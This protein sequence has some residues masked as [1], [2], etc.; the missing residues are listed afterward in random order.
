MDGRAV[1]GG[2]RL[3]A[4]S[5]SYYEYL[6]KNAI[7]TQSEPNEVDFEMHDSFRRVLRE[8]YSIRRFVGK[9][10]TPKATKKSL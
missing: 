5:D 8:T 7:M 1:G 4:G 2:P 3:G 6:A 9:Q 10:K